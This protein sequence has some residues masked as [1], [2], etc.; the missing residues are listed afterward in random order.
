MDDAAISQRKSE[1][2]GVRLLIIKTETDF[3]TIVFGNCPSEVFVPVRGFKT[4][5]K[6]LQGLRGSQHC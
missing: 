6:L 2:F 3:F 4:E 5:L 1:H